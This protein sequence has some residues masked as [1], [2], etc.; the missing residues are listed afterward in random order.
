MEMGK[1]VYISVR[2]LDLDWVVGNGF[3]RGNLK[4]SSENE[5]CGFRQQPCL[6]F[7]RPFCFESG[8]V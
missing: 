6:Y 7:R 4:R 1:F 8:M 3:D 2:C 5:V